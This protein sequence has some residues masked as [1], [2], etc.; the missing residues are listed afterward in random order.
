MFVLGAYATAPGNTHSKDKS[1]VKLVA[2]EGER[3]EAVYRFESCSIR[4]EFAPEVQLG[5]T[6]L[7]L[8][9][10]LRTITVCDKKTVAD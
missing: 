10:Q 8:P 5:W 4:A 3:R 7:L 2:Y 6:E 1:I 9:L